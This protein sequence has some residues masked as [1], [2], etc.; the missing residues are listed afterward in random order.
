MLKVL[1]KSDKKDE[2]WNSPI[3][4]QYWLKIQ[5]GEY[6]VWALIVAVSKNTSI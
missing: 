3:L 1:Q 5:V 4:P 2:I 6:C